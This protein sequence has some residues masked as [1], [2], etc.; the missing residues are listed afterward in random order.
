MLVI[1]V[2]AAH[3]AGI[4]VVYK[5]T[6]DNPA[7]ACLSYGKAVEKRYREAAALIKMAIR[8]EGAFILDDPAPQSPDWHGP[9]AEATCARC[10]RP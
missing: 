6:K 2:W 9:T 3:Q 7:H 4:D 8:E 1:C 5:P 10:R